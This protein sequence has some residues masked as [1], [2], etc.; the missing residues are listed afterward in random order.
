MEFYNNWWEEK[1]SAYLYSIMAE[2]EENIL[3]KKLFLDLKGA[4]EKQAGAWEMK[5]K[6]SNLKNPPAFVPD[7]R[8][9]IV[10]TLVKYFGTESMHT[11]LS[12]MK[13]R[14]M[15]VFTRYHN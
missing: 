11:I 2:N 1:R 12:A 13:I 4:A 9:R 8:T 3:H 6:Q 7:M 10:A 14:G 15:S 5:I